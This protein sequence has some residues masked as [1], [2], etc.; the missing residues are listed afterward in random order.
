MDTA[1]RNMVNASALGTSHIFQ[2]LSTLP[3]SSPFSVSTWCV[4][5][6]RIGYTLRTERLARP[7]PLAVAPIP[8]G[9]KHCKTYSDSKAWECEEY[10]H[11]CGDN[12]DDEIRSDQSRGNHWRLNV[13]TGH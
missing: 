7:L 1:D 10:Q 2:P 3:C 5:K 11:R 8:E 9:S 13:E 6:N 4:D 12:S